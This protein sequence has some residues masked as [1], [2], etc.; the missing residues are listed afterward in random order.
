[1]E[2]KVHANRLLNF[3]LLGLPRTFVLAEQESRKIK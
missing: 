1:M 2:K 3:L